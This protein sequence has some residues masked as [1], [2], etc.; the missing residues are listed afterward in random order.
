VACKEDG[1]VDISVPV[2]VIRGLDT[3]EVKLDATFDKKKLAPGMYLASVEGPNEAEEAEVR[4]GGSCITFVV[5][6][7]GEK[8]AVDFSKVL[9]FLKKQAGIP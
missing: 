6:D 1:T 5:A 8:P 4:E 2:A 3:K 9:R 7:P